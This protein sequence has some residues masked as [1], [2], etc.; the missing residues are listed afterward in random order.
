M[1]R[2]FAVATIAA[3]RLGDS[4]HRQDAFAA[5]AA[6]RILLLLPRFR[7]KLSQTW[8]GTALDAGVGHCVGRAE[9]L[10]VHDA[11]PVTTDARVAAP[12]RNGAM[13]ARPGSTVGGT[14][15]L[16][17]VAKAHGWGRRVRLGDVRRGPPHHRRDAGG[18]ESNFS[19]AGD[20]R[21][22]KAARRLHDRHAAIQ[23]RE[24]QGQ[25]RTST[26]EL[27]SMETS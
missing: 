5:D 3:S 2:G 24:H 10:H 12:H 26:A 4:R 15:Q 9:G 22:L 20:G 7:H 6:A 11:D 18:D 23:H 21:G 25:G 27:V 14:Y 19:C 13:Q 8:S 1:F 17:T 16:P